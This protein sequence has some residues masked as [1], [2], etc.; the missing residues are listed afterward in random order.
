MKKLFFLFCTLQSFWAYTQVTAEI[1]YNNVRAI[2]NNNGIFFNAGNPVTGFVVPKDEGVSSM[3]S[4]SFWMGGLNT[5]NSL[6]LAALR[7]AEGPEFSIGPKSSNSTSDDFMNK[8]NH[9]WRIS[10]QEILDHQINYSNQGYEVPWNI[11][12]WP[13]NGNTAYGEA[14]QLAP[15]IDANSDGIYNPLQGDYPEIR[16]NEALYF[17][18]NDYNNPHE[19]SGGSPIGVDI[20]V[21][22]YVFKSES[23]APLNNCV[24]ISLKIRNSGTNMLSDFYVGFYND[25]D[26]GDPFDDY[27]ASDSLRNMTYAYNGDNSDVPA[28]GTIGYGSYLPAQGCMFLNHSM[29]KSVYYYNTTGPNGEPSTP[30]HYYNYLRGI[31]KDNTEITEGGSGYGGSV[32][33]NYFYSGDPVTNSG[34]TEISSENPPADRRMV[35]STGPFTF[36]PGEQLCI[37]VAFPFARSSQE[38]NN[39][40]AIV[41]LRQAADFIQNFYDT[42][43]FTCQ[44]NTVGLEENQS[45]ATTVSVFPNPGNG[46]FRINSAD[47][48]SGIELYDSLGKRVYSEDAIRNNQRSIEVDLTKESKGMYFYQTHNKDGKVFSG[49]LIVE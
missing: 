47:A 10:Q 35:M 46:L 32:P 44:T 49:K 33:A 12:T 5:D 22:T 15:Y 28:S 17:M 20:H 34:W 26:L 14:N 36:L 48:I 37:D 30:E 16:G 41:E 29:A 43:T 11:A 9:V 25:F 27:V 13:G 19:E 31:W 1:E 38:Y 6:K 7:Y 24:F 3:Y 45:A 23:E 2:V 42:N 8:Y 4:T 18:L 39:V 40:D 21:L